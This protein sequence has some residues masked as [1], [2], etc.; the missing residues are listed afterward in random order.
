MSKNKT[1]S[2]QE[3]VDQQNQMLKQ[4]AD[5]L[6]KLHTDI[7]AEEQHCFDH[8]KIALNLAHQAGRILLKLRKLI[9]HGGWPVRF[10]VIKGWCGWLKSS[11]AQE[12]ESY[13]LTR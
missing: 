9:P 11:S 1:G 4:Y 2:N 13:Q 10:H 12:K 7:V 5:E 6:N 3:H 8:G